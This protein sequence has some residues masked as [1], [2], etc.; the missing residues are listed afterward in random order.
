MAVAIFPII[1]RPVSRLLSR[2]MFN[3]R[4]RDHRME[5]FGRFLKLWP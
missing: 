5:Q 3:A 2:D 1:G 4:F